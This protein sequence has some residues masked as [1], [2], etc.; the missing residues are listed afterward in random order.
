MFN[1]IIRIL[2][3]SLFARN[4]AVVLWIMSRLLVVT[5][6]YTYFRTGSFMDLTG[7][8]GVLY[9]GVLIAIGLLIWLGRAHQIIEEERQRIEWRDYVKKRTGVT[10]NI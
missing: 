2:E 1:W 4:V 10:I 8:V 3:T 6:T 9:G 5:Q 7:S